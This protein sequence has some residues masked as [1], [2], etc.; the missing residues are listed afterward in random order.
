MIQ[1]YLHNV[2][3]VAPGGHELL[4]AVQSDPETAV[5]ECLVPSLGTQSATLSLVGLAGANMAEDFVTCITYFM[6]KNT[7]Q[8]TLLNILNFNII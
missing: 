5:Y 2:T 6:R 4:P 3:N 8:R 1:F 7:M